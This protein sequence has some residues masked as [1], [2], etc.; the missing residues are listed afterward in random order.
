M[1]KILLEHIHFGLLLVSLT[2]LKR[3]A[4]LADV[5]RFDILWSEAVVGVDGWGHRLGGLVLLGGG[6]WKY[7]CRPVQHGSH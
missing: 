2:L 6:Y 4:V 7:I 1:R 3:G 5:I